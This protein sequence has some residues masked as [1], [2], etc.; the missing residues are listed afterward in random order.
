MQIGLKK[1][2]PI[3]ISISSNEAVQPEDT[4]T[5]LA[6]SSGD[7]GFKLPMPA[8]RSTQSATL[9]TSSAGAFCQKKMRMA[10]CWKPATSNQKKWRIG[11]ICIF[12]IISSS[13][14]TIF[15]ASSSANWETWVRGKLETSTLKAGKSEK[16]YCK[17]ISACL[18]TRK[19]INPKNIEE[20][21]PS[22]AFKL[23]L[24]N[25]VCLATFKKNTLGLN[26]IQQSWQYINI[27]QQI[28]TRNP[29]PILVGLSPLSIPPILLFKLQN[30]RHFCRRFTG[31][32]GTW[33]RF[34]TC[35]SD[36]SRM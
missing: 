24:S 36:F 8:S 11:V 12:Y 15:F 1:K 27:C 5:F 30:A 31:W 29:P 2:R 17:L 26:K 4:P 19:N 33:F 18:K 13:C 34:S 20:K 28:L 35:S 21:A 9:V 7:F 23:W 22:F 3:Y 32:A 14:S 6:K 10:F 16:L 25:A